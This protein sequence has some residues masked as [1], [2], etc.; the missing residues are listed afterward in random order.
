MD[1]STTE[2][3]IQDILKKAGLSD[4]QARSYVFL[5]ENGATTPNQLVAAT[6]ESRTNAYMILDKLEK[7]GLAKKSENSQKAA[8]LPLHPSGLESLAEKRRKVV[9]N[10][11]RQVKNAIPELINYFNQH[12][13]TPGVQIH[14]GQD[15]VKAV[16]ERILSQNHTLYMVRSP[17]DVNRE[18][19]SLGEFIKQR[20]AKGIQ[21][22]SLNPVEY[23]R[24]PK[25]FDRK[26]L[27][28]RTFLP[29]G[30]YDSPVEID[31]FGNN[32]AFIDYEN[33]QMSTV[34]ESKNIAQAM[35]QLFRALQ[36]HVPP[37]DPEKLPHPAEQTGQNGPQY[38][39]QSAQKPP[40]RPGHH[41]E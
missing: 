21:L 23:T 33:D 5:V 34:I 36:R 1:H 26:M 19:D 3:N 32:V 39:P 22:K 9:E 15:G 31:I 7:L 38:P 16:F 30:S 12:Q 8:Y 2:T 35:L 10:N 37:I 27:M 17:H 14:Y 20:V 4:S 6:G 11:E 13:N 24:H 41:R 40:F 29:P 28:Q 18:Q 25:E